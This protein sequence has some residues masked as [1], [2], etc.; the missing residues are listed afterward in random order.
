M[1]LS[2]GYTFPGVLNGVRGG[3][4]GLPG[5]GLIPGAGPCISTVAPCGMLP[6]RTMAS[7]FPADRRLSSATGWELAGTCMNSPGSICS[8]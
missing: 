5:L 8:A 2:P 1:G 3:N 7:L 4:V 6:I